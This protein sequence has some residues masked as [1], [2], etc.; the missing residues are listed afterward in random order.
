MA[1]ATEGVV[2]FIERKTAEHWRFYGQPYLLSQIGNDCADAHLK[3]RI[4]AG[5]NSLRN[6]LSGTVSPSFRVTQHPE[7]QELIGLVPR[8]AEYDWNNWK[9]KNARVSIEPNSPPSSSWPPLAPI[10]HVPAAFSYG[11]SANNTIVLTPS[12]ANVPRLPFTTSRQD[13]YSRLEACRGL[14]TDLMGDLERQQYQ[15]RV[16][17]KVEIEKYRNRLPDEYGGGSIML[18]DAAARTLRSMF[19]AEFDILPLPFLAR[20][21]TLLEHHIG[22]RAFYQEL[23]TFYRD[24]KAGRLQ[25]PLPLDAVEGVIAAVKLHTPT[26]FDPSVGEAIDQSADA[27]PLV[28]NGTRPDETDPNQ[29]KLAP[30]PLGELP[31]TEARD[32]QVAGVVN[33]LW[34]VFSLG[35]K[36]EKS[37]KGWHAAYEMLASPVAEVLRWLAHFL[38]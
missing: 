29:P 38:K 10:E 27:A 26:L 19:E 33:E 28:Y 22:L 24:V 37:L 11:W 8:T 15:V 36:F 4:P 2:E 16:D 25:E 14:A 6:F 13:H 17:Y 21:K 31:P 30:D 9:P 5:G 18:S 7:R 23:E 12:E 35:E 34:R 3:W 1:P 20:L 32:F